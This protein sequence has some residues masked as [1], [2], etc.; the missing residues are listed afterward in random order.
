[1]RGNVLVCAHI[2]PW[3]PP[4]NLDIF[5]LVARAFATHMPWDTKTHGLTRPMTIPTQGQGEHLIVED[6]S[7][8][9]FTTQAKSNIG[10][11]YCWKLGPSWWTRKQQD[12]YIWYL[13]P[14][15]FCP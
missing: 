11:K 15:T 5:F 1:M 4:L 2:Y 7:Y 12:T 9:D 3:G 14:I 13:S 6:F 8:I 10:W